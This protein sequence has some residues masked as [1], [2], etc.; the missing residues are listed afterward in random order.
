MA[1]WTCPRL[2]HGAVPYQLVAPYQVVTGCRLPG[3][4]GDTGELI[5]CGEDLMDEG[6]KTSIALLSSTLWISLRHSSHD[7]AGHCI[8]CEDV[9]SLATYPLVCAFPSSPPHFPFPYPKAHPRSVP[10]H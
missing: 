1:P 4:L 5:L 6:T 7:G 9:T 8:C 2:K 10:L 3:G